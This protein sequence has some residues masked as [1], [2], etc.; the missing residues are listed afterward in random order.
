MLKEL[1]IKQVK[2]FEG[3]RPSLD[4][5]QAQNQLYSAQNDLLQAKINVINKKAEIETILNTSN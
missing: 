2:F 3:N 1:K 4:L 5:R